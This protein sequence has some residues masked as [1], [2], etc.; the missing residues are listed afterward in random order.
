MSSTSQPKIV[1]KRIARTAVVLLIAAAAFFLIRYLPEMLNRD[2]SPADTHGTLLALKVDGGKSQAVLISKDGT[3][4]LAPGF[5][6]GT[7]DREAS[8][9]PDGN[10]IFISRSKAS[11][12]PEESNYQLYRWNPANGK[13]ERRTIGTRALAH[14]RF[15]PA[16]A[17]NPNAEALVTAGGKVLVFNPLKD[18]ST[19]QLLPPSKNEVSLDSKGGGESDDSGEFAD[20]YRNLGTSFREARWTAD[21]KMAVAVMRRDGGEAL[22]IQKLEGPAE[23]RRPRLVAVGDRIEFDVAAKSNKVVYTILNF[24]WPDRDNIPEQFRKDGKVT[25]PFHHALVFLDL[26]SGQSQPVDISQDDKR[27]FGSVAIGPDDSK[28]LT[29][30]GNFGSAPDFR[31]E[32]LVLYGLAQGIQP[33]VLSTGSIFDPCWHPSGGRIAFVKRAGGQSQPIYELDIEGN[34]VERLL[35]KPGASYAK[36]SYSPQ[37][38]KS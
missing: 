31:P 13:V 27:A 4:N 29:V 18:G 32:A 2:D 12:D 30:G 11:K 36:P 14:P 37:G 24:Q 5:E 3:E 26:D 33:K 21:R 22:I 35:S 15:S 7:D 6:P 10:R 20:Q 17:A 38:D 8:W 9:R 19:R 34:G 28:V 25:R 23:E 16:D 1:Q